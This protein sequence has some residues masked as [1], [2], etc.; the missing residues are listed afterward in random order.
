LNAESTPTYWLDSP[1][2][3]EISAHKAVRG[4]TLSP[5]SSIDIGMAET[6][7]E[8]QLSDNE[9]LSDHNM[10]NNIPA[11]SEYE[12][13]STHDTSSYM[14]VRAVAPCSTQES[15]EALNAVAGLS[16]KPSRAT[17][18][19]SDPFGNTKR[20]AVGVL[21]RTKR[22]LTSDDEESEQTSVKAK[23]H[24]R[25]PQKTPKFTP[26]ETTSGPVGNSKSAKGSRLLNEQVANGTFTKH[27]TK[28]PRFVETIRDM[29]KDA[30]FDIDDDPRKVRHS[31]C[32]RPQ[33]MDEPYNTSA[34]KKH[35]NSCS[36]PTKAIQKI[37][38]HSRGSQTLFSMA[39]KHKWNETP[40]ADPSHSQRV[41][42]PC[43]G[44]TP[45]NVSP[46]LKKGFKTY[47]ARTPLPGGG[48][49]S[50]DEMRSLLFPER[51]YKSLSERQKNEVRSAQRQRYRWHNHPDLQKIFSTSCCKTVHIQRNAQPTPAC[52]A[53]VELVLDK[54]FKRA[55]AVP[56]PLDENRKFT[57]KSLTD[58][59]AIQRYGLVSGLKDLI[60]ASE[61]VRYFNALSFVL[62]TLQSRT[63]ACLASVMPKRSLMVIT[64]Q[65]QMLYLHPLSRQWYISMTR[66]SVALGCKV[67][68]TLQG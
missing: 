38:E 64:K 17:H 66:K 43:P 3:V 7:T 42:L 50:T 48:G 44:L 25:R 59:A 18:K 34:F 23:S 40:P 56:L 60:D 49:S 52:S 45:F 10:Q 57:P 27:K 63:H 28:W 35:I 67:F 19:L 54:D 37:M 33:K 36:G 39:K 8:H 6:V 47:L 55:L 1:A 16:H 5:N 53:C 29:D 15:R 51:T 61:A 2:Q 58:K 11:D 21:E 30:E 32:K 22:K 46:S 65:V 68:V 14:D 31:L 12:S 62:L 4:R 26:T 41:D 13:S 24:D 9:M 20:Q